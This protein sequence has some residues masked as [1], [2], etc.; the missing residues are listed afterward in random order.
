VFSSQDRGSYSEQMKP[1]GK[2]PNAYM[3]FKLFRV[4]EVPTPIDGQHRGCPSYYGGYSRI[5]ALPDQL[6]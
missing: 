3:E 1:F 4:I 6:E 2:A 5:H